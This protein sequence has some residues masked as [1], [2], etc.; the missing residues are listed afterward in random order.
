MDK[1]KLLLIS[2][3]GFGFGVVA[4]FLYSKGVKERAVDSVTTK[5]EGGNLVISADIAKTVV[6]FL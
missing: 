6:G 5:F 4:G 3:A 2:L 1:K